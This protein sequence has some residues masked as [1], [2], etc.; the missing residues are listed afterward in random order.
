[1]RIKLS[2]KSNRILLL[3]S[4]ITLE[5]HT[6]VFQHPLQC[7]RRV[8]SWSAKGPQWFFLHKREKSPLQRPR[9]E[10]EPSSLAIA[11][12]TLVNTP[13]L[14]TLASAQAAAMKLGLDNDMR[15]RIHAAAGFHG[16]V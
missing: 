3:S 9:Q 14:E 8:S 10:E 15:L 2:S 6:Q 12:Q 5:H 4:V 13:E 11:S 1:M 16:Y 7:Q